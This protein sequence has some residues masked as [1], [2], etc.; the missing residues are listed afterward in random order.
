[1][2]H[3]LRTLCFHDETLLFYNTTE[4]SP[5]KSR[6]QNNLK[7]VIPVTPNDMSQ[8]STNCRPSSS[9][10]KQHLK[11]EEYSEQRP[12]HC[13][14]FEDYKRSWRNKKNQVIFEA[15]LN[16]T[17]NVTSHSPGKNTRLWNLYHV[18]SSSI[19]AFLLPIHL[20]QHHSPLLE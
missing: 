10:S 16:V 19:S 17:R 9:S 2:S 11:H 1:M 13:V 20:L 14:I 18:M 6:T 4:S 5:L 15:Q 3:K 8:L 12:Y 7:A